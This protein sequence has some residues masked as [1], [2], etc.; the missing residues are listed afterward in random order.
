MGRGAYR[1]L[2][3]S[4][5]GVKS[6]PRGDWTNVKSAIKGTWTPTVIRGK[7]T[8]RICCLYCGFIFNLYGHNIDS[9]GVV[10]PAVDC[11]VNTCRYHE[12][13]KLGRWHG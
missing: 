2:R 10:R 3:K 8:A 13:I 1:P 5:V 7:K 6:I 11:P 4:K 9:E 12:T